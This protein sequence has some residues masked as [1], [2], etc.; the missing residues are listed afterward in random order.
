MGAFALKSSLL[1]TL[2]RSPVSGPEI[3]RRTRI[4]SSAER[5]IGPSLSSDQQSVMAPVRGTRP[6]VGLSPVVPQRIDGSMM[7][8][9]VSLP[10]ENPTHA[11]AVAA[12]G[13]AL[14]PPA[15]SSRSHGFIVW[16]P[17]QTSF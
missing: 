9:S 12:P 7:L 8:P 17:N 3:A 15:P 1:G 4:A 11:A 5:V 14:L 10:I 6:N 2:E 16:P 13:P